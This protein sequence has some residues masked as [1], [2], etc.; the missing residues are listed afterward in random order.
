[1]VKDKKERLS[2]NILLSTIIMKKAYDKK[3][4]SRSAKS[5]NEPNKQL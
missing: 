5:N 1:M 4:T 3:S 2:T